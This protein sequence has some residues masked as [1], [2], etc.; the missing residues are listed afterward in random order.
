V[1]KINDLVGV[2]FS[3]LSD[4]VI[5]DVADEND[6]IRVMAR[7][8]DK[9]VPCPMCGVLTGRVHGFYGWT[10]T[11]VPVDGRRVVEV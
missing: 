10:V 9:P 2:V 4:L 11:D 1:L 3:G 5:E 6:L 8:R 7:T